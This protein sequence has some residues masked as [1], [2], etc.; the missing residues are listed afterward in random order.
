M[1]GGVCTEKKMENKV[2]WGKNPRNNP[3]KNKL[4]GSKSA[5]FTVT[6]W[7]QGYLF[8]IVLNTPNA[9]YLQL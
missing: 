9:K 6:S 2:L 5:S 1:R 4:R 7:R 8:N 3:G